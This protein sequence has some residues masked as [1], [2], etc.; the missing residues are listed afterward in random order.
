MNKILKYFSIALIGLSATS[1]DD[2]FE[3]KPQN[4]MVLEDFW[5]T[6][7]DVLSVVGSCYRSMQEPG[8]M[9][10]LIVWG[11]FRSDN[12]ILGSG[13]GGDLNNIANLNLLPANGYSSWG[14]FYSVINL[15]NTVEHFAPL[16]YENDPNFTEGQLKGYL[17]EVK[18]VRAFCYYTLV[19]AFR[20]IPFSTEPV[21]DDTVVFRKPQA[22]PDSIVNFLID[23]L[24]K[25]EP[26][27][28]TEWSKEEYTK[29]RMT[30][31][32][33]RCLIADMCLWQGRYAEAEEYC[34]RVLTD[35]NAE[36]ML[37][38]PTNYNKRVFVDGNSTESIF[39][40]QFN[41]SIIPNY[42]ICEFY[43]ISGGRGP[44]KQIVAYDFT[45]T[46]LWD[47]TDV[48]QYDFYFADEAAGT[49][50]IKKFVAYRNEIDI[51]TQLRESNYVN[52]GDNAGNTNWILYRLPDIY[53]MKAEALT[54]QNKS[55]DEAFTLVKMVYD[56]AN[57]ASPEGLSGS[58]GNQEAMRELILDERQR[59]FMFEGKRYFDLLRA[60]KKDP[61]RMQLIVST[62]LI[63]K[64]ITL[65]QATVSSKMKD[66]DALYMPINEGELKANHQ[67][68]QNPFYETSSDID[69]KK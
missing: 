34:N 40:L 53:L 7:S 15:C 64:Y 68:K 14:D 21:I 35:G 8:F 4:E 57:S 31:N 36:L 47:E 39:E 46:E 20:D 43:G 60:I 5:K 59:E 62:Y 26:Y 25:I 12:C 37:V 67:L 66:L 48:R 16:A 63:P 29:G 69:I 41:R 6:E 56:R 9:Q 1:C 49:F 45:T 3:L 17:A 42:A 32:A 23:D 2:F 58:Y 28:I 19:R 22:D 33:I 52:V 55:L 51:P 18:G 24:I 50:P 30:Q 10:R 61:S 27:A 54:E 65:D 13:D 44:Q 11:E 38:N